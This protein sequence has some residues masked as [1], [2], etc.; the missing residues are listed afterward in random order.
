[1]YRDVQKCLH[2]V[3]MRGQITGSFVFLLKSVIHEIFPMDK[4]IGRMLPSPLP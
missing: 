2:I 1:M 4:A 3:N